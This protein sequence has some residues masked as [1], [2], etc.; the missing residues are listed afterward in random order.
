MFGVIVPPRI[1]PQMEIRYKN[2]RRE[3]QRMEAFEGEGN[4]V[5]IE[6]PDELNPKLH[7]TIP[8]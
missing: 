8:F 5:L 7:R 6:T 1:L 2:P 4:L 3:K